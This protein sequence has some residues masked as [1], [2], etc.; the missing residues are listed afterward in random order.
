MGLR[1]P[2][3]K[4]KT[5]LPTAEAPKP[6]WDGHKSRAAAVIAFIESLTVTSGIL[7]GQ[8]FKLRPWQRQIVKAWYRT[9]RGRRVVR[10]G[11]L[12]VGRKNGKTGLCAA[13]ALCHLLGPEHEK[14]GQ[15]VIGA[16]DRDQSG[17]VFNEV[18]A[19]I[20]DNPWMEAECNIKRHEKT[21][22]HLPSGSILKALSSDAA[23]AHGLSP[24]VVILDE[25]AQWGD[26]IGRRL[27]DALT[28]GSGAR[29]EPLVLIISTQSERDSSL[30]S[31]LVD[32]GKQ[33]NA[34]DVEDE[35]FS[36]FI[37]ETPADADIWNPESWKASNPALGDFRSLEDIEM[38][39]ERARRMPALEAAFRNLNLNQRVAAE[40]R[41]IPAAEWMACQRCEKID[42]VD[43]LAAGACYGGLDLGSVRDLTSLALFWPEFGYVKVWSWC[44]ADNMAERE[45]RDRVPYRVWNERGFIEATPG[46]ATNKRIVAVRLGEIAAKYQPAGIAYDI[47]G[48]PELERILSEE[49]ITLPLVKWGQGYKSMS[50]AT[51]ATEERILNRTLIHD[52][53]P[54]LTWCV[55]NV[56]IETDGAG[57]MKPSKDRSHERIDAAVAMVMAV[58]LAAVEAPAAVYDFSLPLVITP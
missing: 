17:I 52:G 21:I 33:V 36:A 40:E 51:K 55:S 44:P 45:E 53:N 11:L 31:T 6:S 42:D 7:A 38:L 5:K 37:F 10:T 46:R 1:G 15:I 27:Y 41:W 34:G 13:L 39:A 49:G 19:Y 58:G 54:V 9:R 3:A 43:L 57:N 4:A 14:R 23:K 48:M 50:P 22:E 28:S 30:M 29:K 2:G 25:L 8:R 24:S 26:G 56:A 16:T 35:R 47:W 20:A 32:Y 18:C 12:S